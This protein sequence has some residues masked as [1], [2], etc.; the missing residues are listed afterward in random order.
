MQVII[1]APSPLNEDERLWAIIDIEDIFDITIYS[2]I[3]HEIFK[4]T[5]LY[6]GSEI[7]IK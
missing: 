2:K 7:E 1:K 5:I 4:Y 3:S 6:G